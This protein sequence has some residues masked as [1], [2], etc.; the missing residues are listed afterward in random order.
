[1]K[2]RLNQKLSNFNIKGALQILAGNSSFVNPNEESLDTLEQK[3]PQVPD[4]LKLPPFPGAT[5]SPVHFS[6]TQILAAIYSFSYGS[7][8]GPKS[9]QPQHLKDCISITVL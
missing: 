5:T 7:G 3:Q 1:M 4:D 2:R 9:L 6:L 8:A